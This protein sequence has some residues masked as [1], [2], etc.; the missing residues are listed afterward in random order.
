MKF[1]EFKWRIWMRLGSPGGLP[2]DR[3]PF[4]RTTHVVF[5]LI[6]VNLH[7]MEHYQTNR[8]INSLSFF[9]TR[10]TCI[11][12]S[13]AV[14]KALSEFPFG[15]NVGIMEI[16]ILMRRLHAIGNFSFVGFSLLA[17]RERL[18]SWWRMINVDI[19]YFRHLRLFI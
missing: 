3:R 18:A 16:S 13:P 6:T 11:G 2:R 15:V 4:R 19:F 14:T 7:F 9:I 12:R 5:K 1:Y 17:R 10:C 8:K